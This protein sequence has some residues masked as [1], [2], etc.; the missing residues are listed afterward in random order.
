MWHPECRFYFAY[1]E[2]AFDAKYIHDYHILWV[3]DEA[4]CAAL[5]AQAPAGGA[6]AAHVASP[7]HP[8]T[9]VRRS[10]LT[11]LSEQGK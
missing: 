11:L 3:K 1:C 8:I 4:A 9:Q 6:A 2:G 5:A 10:C 7:I